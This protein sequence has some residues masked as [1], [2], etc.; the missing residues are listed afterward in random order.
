MS[1]PKPFSKLLVATDFSPAARRALEHAAAWARR[2]GAALHLFFSTPG[3]QW[4]PEAATTFS[5]EAEAVLEAARKYL[6]QAARPLA[7]EG[8]AVT[9]GVAEGWPAETILA[10]AA[11]AGCDGIVVGTRGLAGWR[12]LVLGSTARRVIEHAFC[13]VLAVHAEDPLPA[14]R[15]RTVL[16]ATDFSEGARQALLRLP[17]L[18][19]LGPEDRVVLSHAVYL[20]PAL[21]P[22]MAPFALPEL[23]AAI[24]GDAALRLEA[25]AQLLR[26]RGLSCG[27]EVVRGYPADTLAARAA[28]LPAD[29][30]VTGSVGR[31]GL[32]HLLL[33]SVAERLTAAAPCPVLVVPPAKALAAPAA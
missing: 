23:E 20:A 25:E 28:E 9:Y 26:E 7:A 32:A 10:E 29:L 19:G 16:L 22:A 15:G 14:D 33:G 18:A 8:L 5:R 30:L 21:V 1:D 24:A 31:T 2:S 13:P 11:A 12:R 4:P 3:G 27:V 6:E 17:A